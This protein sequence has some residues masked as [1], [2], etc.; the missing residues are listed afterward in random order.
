[1]EPKPKIDIGTVAALGVAVGGITSA[2][3]L[4][5]TAF[6]GLGYWIP[7]GVL[8]LILA[9]SG[10]SMVLAW[11]K[12]RQRNLGPI[13]DANGWAVNARAK[14]NIPFGASLTNVAK[15]PPG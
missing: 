13:L 4:F 9:I 12:L 10:P 5:M 14:I 15:L 8:G 1:P 3:A 2:L 6:L 11:L 7:A